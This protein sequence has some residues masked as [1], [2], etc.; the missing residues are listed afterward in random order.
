[1]FGAGDLTAAVPLTVLGFYQLYFLTDVARIGPALAGWS[2]LA[3][4]LWDA[5]NDPIVGV[6]ADRLSG[7]GGRRRGPLILSALPLSILFAVSWLVPPF[8]PVDLAIWYSFIFTAFD[9][10]FTVYHISFNS[11]TP[12]LAKDYDERSSLNGFRMAFSIGGTLA[13]V[14]LMVLLERWLADPVRR[15]AISGA[16]MGAF[17]L[18]P[19]FLA[20]RASD[21]FDT[22]SPPPRLSLVESIGKTLGNKPFRHVMGLYLFSWTT[23]A[24]ISSTLVY[25]AAYYLRRPQEANLFILVAEV[26]A[27]AFIP[28]IVALSKAWDKRRA[29]MAACLFWIIVQALIASLGR[30]A[31]IFAYIL[32]ALSGAGIAAAYVLPWSMIPDVIDQDELETGERREGSFYSFASFFQKLGTALALWAM[33][34]I[35]ASSGYIV[36][37]TAVPYPDQPAAA[38]E[39]LRLFIGIA[40][41]V[42]LAIAVAIAFRYDLGRESH[43][44]L[45]ME[46][47]TRKGAGTSGS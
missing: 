33:A 28:G 41:A 20:W 15:F 5:I 10:C 39:A 7:K 4:K 1:M 2:I 27:I 18:L 21:G 8:S 45:L 38:V 16:L 37:S 30:D 14:I 22:A 35:L 12:S 36:P 3:V 25:F 29:F 6:L 43:R 46:R 24:I 31:I 32:A 17:C 34:R 42:L 26:S 13:A 47:E 9:T 40:P 23:T 19:A 44:A 11:L